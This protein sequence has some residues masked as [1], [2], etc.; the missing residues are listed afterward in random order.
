MTNMPF[1][2]YENY[3]SDIPKVSTI[4]YLDLFLLD[5]PTLD[6]DRNN[7]VSNYR[8]QGR[9]DYRE[10]SKAVQNWSRSYTKSC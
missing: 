3:P 6:I 2:H 1:I 8:K 4:I 10:R 5:C 9:M 7:H